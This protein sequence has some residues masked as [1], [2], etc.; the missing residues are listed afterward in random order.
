MKRERVSS[1]SHTTLNKNNFLEKIFHLKSSVGKK[2]RIGFALSALGLGGTG[3]YRVLMGEGGG[4]GMSA[5]F[6]CLLLTS[7]GFV[8]AQ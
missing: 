8:G 7:L 6:D 2:K 5:K 3:G 1:N 4:S